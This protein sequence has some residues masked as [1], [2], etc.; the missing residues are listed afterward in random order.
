MEYEIPYWTVKKL[1]KVPKIAL[2]LF[3]PTLVG[4]QKNKHLAK[5]PRLSYFKQLK[6]LFVCR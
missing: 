2:L 1:N 3:F 6:E 4:F 5:Y